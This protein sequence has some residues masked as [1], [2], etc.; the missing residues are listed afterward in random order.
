MSNTTTVPTRAEFTAALREQAAAE[1]AWRA[2]LRRHD[3][4]GYERPGEVAA[5]DLR[6]HEAQAA[7]T[8]LVDRL[9]L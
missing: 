3:P 4:L 2:Y 6:C 8:A 7:V 5:I 9:P 1:D